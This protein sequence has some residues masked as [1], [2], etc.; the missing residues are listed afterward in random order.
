M[1]LRI[2]SLSAAGE[3]GVDCGLISPFFSGLVLTSASEFFRATPPV[4][5]RVLAD[6]LTPLGPLERS[7]PVDPL[8]AMDRPDDD[9]VDNVLTE[10]REVDALINERR[11]PGSTYERYRG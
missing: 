10:P 8:E 11:P 6:P 1:A 2:T 5:P 4:V 3:W 9:A 7:D